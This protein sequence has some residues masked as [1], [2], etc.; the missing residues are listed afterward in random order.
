MIETEVDILSK[1]H[2][3]NIIKLEEVFETSEKVFMIM[4]IIQGGE[5]FDKIVELQSYTE[6][7]ASH[8]VAQIL[9]A[10]DHLHENGI[11][12]R[13][14]K[15]ENLFLSSKE[16]DAQVKVGDFGL[17]T[18]LPTDGS[19]L[20]KAVGT[21][22][23]I[24]PEILQTL[25][26]NLDGYGKEVDLWSVGII[27]YI[28]LCGFPPFYAEDD[29]EAFDQIISGEFDFPSPYWD[30]ISRDA[31]DLIKHLLVVEASKRYTTK[32]ALQHPWIKANN[33]G[34]HLDGTIEQLKHFNAKKKWKKGINTVLAMGRFN[35]GLKGLKISEKKQE[36]KT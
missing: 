3:P 19:K 29:D 36:S 24:A 20:T 12:H 7:D 21:P 6:K 32:S 33:E 4:E 9:S 2:H 10:V 23:Y 30:H 16:D 8:L 14:L 26:E 11:V 15:P 17:S 28:L 22:G 31:K 25:D 27:M 34:K 35:S 18:F 5:L 13:D 1:V